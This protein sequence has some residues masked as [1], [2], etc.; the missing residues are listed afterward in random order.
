MLWRA[1]RAPVVLRRTVRSFAMRWCAVLGLRMSLV[2]SSFPVLA[3]RG[4]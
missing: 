1:A 2:W 3:R 4:Q